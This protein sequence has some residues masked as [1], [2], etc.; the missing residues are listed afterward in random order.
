MHYQLINGS[1]LACIF[2]KSS[3]YNLNLGLVV[4]NPQNNVAGLQED[5]STWL[6]RPGSPSSGRELHF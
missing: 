5:L 4:G 3:S 2:N 6:A 1:K